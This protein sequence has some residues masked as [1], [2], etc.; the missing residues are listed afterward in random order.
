MG[1]WARTF[2]SLAHLGGLFDTQSRLTP[3][4][5][6]FS[7]GVKTRIRVSSGKWL[8]GNRCGQLLLFVPFAEL[9]QTASS[10]ILKE[11]V[12]HTR[13]PRYPCPRLMEVPHTIPFGCVNRKSALSCP[14]Y[15][16]ALR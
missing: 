1:V 4:R 16:L 7:F 10:Q 11:Q 8:L 5:R 12:R 6:L 15:K 13:S 14:S 9:N 2:C 3:V